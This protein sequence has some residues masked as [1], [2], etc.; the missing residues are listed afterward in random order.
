MNL[1]SELNINFFEIFSFRKITPSKI[2]TSSTNTNL[3]EF[4]ALKNK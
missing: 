1:I 4:E 3:K 2:Q